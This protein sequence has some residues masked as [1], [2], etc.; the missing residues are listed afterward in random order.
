MC[1]FLRKVSSGRALSAVV[2]ILFFQTMEVKAACEDPLQSILD[3]L[4]CVVAENV[5]CASSGYNAD[6]FVKIHNGVDTNTTID[7]SGS[8][9]A[10][11][12]SLIDISFPS[13]DFQMNYG[14]NQASIRYI[15]KVVMT[16]GSGFGLPSS[17]EYPFSQTYYQHEHALVTVD[18]D[19]KMIKWD[20]YGDNAEQDV[21]NKAAN[22]IL[23]MIGFLPAEACV[24]SDES[25]K[26]T[27]SP[28]QKKSSWSR[29]RK[30]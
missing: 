16:D 3:T 4:D 18:D 1:T 11:A 22:D 25:E 9:W 21:V 30:I 29:K 6:E 24:K 10:G 17:T 7:S 14:E 20:Q 15:E 12:F 23:C 2:T 13:I 26:I 8:Y 28:K 19:C 5:T 27:K